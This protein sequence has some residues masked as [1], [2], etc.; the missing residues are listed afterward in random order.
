[1]LIL[2][3]VAVVRVSG[4]VAPIDTGLEGLVDVVGDEGQT[5]NVRRSSGADG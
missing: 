1:M 2:G 5:P 3:L 4:E